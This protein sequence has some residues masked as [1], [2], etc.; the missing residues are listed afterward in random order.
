MLGTN[1]STTANTGT[2][3]RVSD[4]WIKGITMTPDQV[5][6]SF[7]AW[8][9]ILSRNPAGI[10]GGIYPAGLTAKNVMTME[11]KTGCDFRVKTVRCFEDHL[12]FNLSI[13]TDKYGALINQL[14][15]V[16]IYLQPDHSMIDR[17]VYSVY[18]YIQHL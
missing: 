11:G 2:R 6:A 5:D 10:F 18:G 15:I 9:D 4:T 17:Q 7:K 1:L 13:Y 8:E 14:K 12:E 16:P 3:L